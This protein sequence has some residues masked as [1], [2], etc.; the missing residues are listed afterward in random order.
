MLGKR[1]KLCPVWKGPYLIVKKRT[2]N[3]FVVQGPRKEMTV[4]HNRIKPCRANDLPIW[5]KRRQQSPPED[6]KEQDWLYQEPDI[7]L[8]SSEIELFCVCRSPDDGKFMI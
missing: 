7:Q 6:D 8:E 4:H 2:A 5:L 3:L 1:K